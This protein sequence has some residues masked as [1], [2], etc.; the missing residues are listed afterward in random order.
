M[1]CSGGLQRLSSD[2][3]GP[4]PI[5]GRLPLN[6]LPNK[7]LNAPVLVIEDEAMIAWMLQSL[8]EDMGFCS[9]TITASGTEAID[10]AD[11]LHPVM[12]VSDIN[13]GLQDMDG[14]DTARTILLSITV[15]VIF[16]SG[17]AGSEARERIT[18]DV[19]GAFILRKPVDVE[20]LRTTVELAAGGS[21]R[22][23]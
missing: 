20:A 5:K 8:L 16:I 22:S 15:P 11:R 7:F 14:I 17:Y 4:T 18:R 10:V 6:P 13:L 23:H 19:P 9:V 12:I 3:G 21:A 2:P 1:L